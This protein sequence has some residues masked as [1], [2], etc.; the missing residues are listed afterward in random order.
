[1]EIG[2]AEW[3]RIIREG[4]RALNVPIGAEIADRFSRYGE[5]LLRWNRRINL[6]AI[7]DPL[8][9]AVK[10]FL[11]SAAVS[12]HIPP[13]ARLLD[14]GAGAGFPGLALKI[15]RPDLEV[16]LVDAVRKKVSFQQ[17]MIRTLSLSGIRAR[18]ARVEDIFESDA[19][20]FDVVICR[21]LTDLPRFFQMAGP[22][23]A[24]NGMCIA[25]KGRPEEVEAEI[26]ASVAEDGP[27]PHWRMIPYTLP[28]LD[29]R[30]TLAIH[31]A[32]NAV[33]E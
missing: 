12:P 3:R 1:M 26:R 31:S 15:L 27:A 16:A 10:H 28:Y 32:S 33:R 20:G 8:E 9:A 18:H 17:H 13:H 22:L 4:G 5:E 2:S 11:D 14:I 21:A 25:M 30:R 29:A 7:T 19:H 6:T 23:L 24:P